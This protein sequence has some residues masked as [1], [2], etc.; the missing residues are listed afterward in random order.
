M[1][2]AS[3]KAIATDPEI[4]QGAMHMDFWLSYRFQLSWVF[5]VHTLLG[6]LKI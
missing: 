5:H 4:N 1:L 2:M 3:E 6:I